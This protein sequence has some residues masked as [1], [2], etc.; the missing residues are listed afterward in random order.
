[1]ITVHNSAE[2]PADWLDA[3]ADGSG[4]TDDRRDK[5]TVNVRRV[6]TSLSQSLT[7]RMN[8]VTP[9]SVAMDTMREGSERSLLEHLE[10]GL[11]DLVKAY[12]SKATKEKQEEMMQSTEDDDDEQ[13]G[14]DEYENDEDDG[15]TVSTDWPSRTSSYRSESEPEPE[16]EPESEPR[17]SSQIV[18]LDEM[19]QDFKKRLYDKLVSEGNDD[20]ISLESFGVEETSRSL[21]SSSPPDE[22]NGNDSKEGGGDQ[23]LSEMYRASVGSTK[24]KKND[25]ETKTKSARKKSSSTSAFDDDKKTLTSQDLAAQVLEH[26]NSSTKPDRRPGFY[27]GAEAVLMEE[28]GEGSADVK[29][30]LRDLFR[31]GKNF[32]E[33][34]SA[35]IN[36]DPL[37]TTAP[38]DLASTAQGDLENPSQSNDDAVFKHNDRK[39]GPGLA[40]MEV[41]IS[42]ISSRDREVFDLLS[43]P[44]RD[45]PAGDFYDG[46]EGTAAPRDSTIAGAN[47]EDILD[48]S[49]RQEVEDARWAVLTLGRIVREDSTKNHD[50][51]E[52]YIFH[53]PDGGESKEVPIDKVAA[54]QQCVAVAIRSGLVEDPQ[55]RIMEDIKFDVMLDEMRRTPP[56]RYPD[57]M[58]SYKDVLL[59][60][61]Y[62][63]IMKDRLSKAGSV[64][65]EEEK[66]MF[67]R[68]NT[69]AMVLLR[70]VR[71]VG[72]EME[73]T[74]LETI[75]EICKVAMDPQYEDDPQKGAW[76]LSDRV[77]SMRPALDDT[78]IAYLKYAIEEEEARLVREDKM[79]DPGENR[80]LMVLRIVQG[81][82]YAE[83]RKRVDRYVEDIW[84]VLRMEEPCERRS[85]L[86]KFVNDLA[87]LDVRPF[88]KAVDNVVAALGGAADVEKLRGLSAETIDEAKT[89]GSFSKQILQL[90][91]DIEE[92]LSAERMDVM[93]KDADEWNKKRKEKA[94]AAAKQRAIEAGKD[95]DGDNSTRI[96]LGGAND[97]DYVDKMP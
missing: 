20:E 18:N 53:P 74:Q 13:K 96:S 71:A 47:I 88:R 79:L 76:A 94:M 81:G 38:G 45:A 42:G 72:A 44:P 4:G 1:M 83:L 48:P 80:W 3:K 85:L 89:L 56:E 32:A 14:Y 15:A 70:E 61:R 19:A 58:S 77:A 97:S 87:T 82:V 11:V 59:S 12:A 8:A 50:E 68:L 75:R 26:L 23:F 41:P 22:G 25:I 36:I 33:G 34:R 90:G 10:G 43:G 16:P 52:H 5:I 49:L 92:V 35:R 21:S 93:A 17:D 86:G 57:V 37:D 39:L 62:S 2:V 40:E 55:S 24:E 9:A 27:E 95:N 64:R 31:A 63:A 65:S 84:Y 73:A 6:T 51:G 60:D 66:E 30:E 7:G 91:S 29:K 69:Y 78:F 28:E 67:N 46:P 54:L